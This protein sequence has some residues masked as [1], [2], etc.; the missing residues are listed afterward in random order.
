[1]VFLEKHRVRDFV[2]AS[3]ASTE[4]DSSY[5]VALNEAARRQ[6]FRAAG[7]CTQDRNSRLHQARRCPLNSPDRQTLLRIGAGAM[8]AMSATRMERLG[9]G[10]FLNRARTVW[11]HTVKGAWLSDFTGFRKQLAAG[12]AQGDRIAL[13]RPGEHWTALL[14]LPP[15]RAAPPTHA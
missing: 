11:P 14:G 9:W 13:R 12:T 1:M 5:F 2:P 15:P 4:N 6:G 7:T 3:A 10:T 8:Q